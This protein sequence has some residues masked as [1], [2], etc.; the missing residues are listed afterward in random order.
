MKLNKITTHH[1]SQEET[2]SN[3]GRLRRFSSIAVLIACIAVSFILGY[4]VGE[5]VWTSELRMKYAFLKIPSFELPKFTFFKPK[6]V[7]SPTPSQAV[8]TAKSTQ[9]QKETKLM[10]GD[11][12]LV[13]PQQDSSKE[14]QDAFGKKLAS[15]ARDATAIT[16]GPSCALDPVVIRM[17]V[18]SLFTV[19]NIDALEK[20]EITFGQGDGKVV[21][22]SGKSETITATM[23]GKGAYSI[24][25]E[26]R[27]AGFLMLAPK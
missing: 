20:H 3:H 16:V 22:E 2:S 23:R 13:P 11:V 25:C 4:K 14:V 8:S 12:E 9:N 10:A 19:K 7:V 5:K 6:G 15:V 24:Q 26:Q 21:V 27:L 17:K 18:D 1:S